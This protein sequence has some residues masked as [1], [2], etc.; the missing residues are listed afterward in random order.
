MVLTK[1]SRHHVQCVV[2]GNNF[3]SEYDA[4]LKAYPIYHPPTMRKHELCEFRFYKTLLRL[5]RYLADSEHSVPAVQLMDDFEWQDDILM[6]K[7]MISWCLVKGFLTVDTFKRLEVPLSIRTELKDFLELL[8]EDEIDHNI[9]NYKRYLR[10]VIPDL[11][12]V[13]P[14]QMPFKKGELKLGDSTL[15]DNI[16]T[17]KVQK[18][19]ERKL[20]KELSSERRV[21]SV[22]SSIENKFTR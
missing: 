8:E 6:K 14:D 7:E 20:D 5:H 11:R 19:S 15:F 1:I 12:A 2:C 4:E 13:S 10:R 3:G 16:D 18:R 21:S 9:E 22:R 17:S